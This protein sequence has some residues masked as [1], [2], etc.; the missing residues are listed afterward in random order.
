MMNDHADV[1]REVSE[2]R[3]S[4]RTNEA[5]AGARRA[6]LDN[7]LLRDFRRSNA[8]SGDHNHV[9][10]PQAAALL[11]LFSVA[12]AAQELDR[13]APRDLLSLTLPRRPV[14]RRDYVEF[15]R[16]FARDYEMTPQAD[17]WGWRHGPLRLMPPLAVFALD[18]DRELGQRVKADLRT[19]ARWV[20]QCV[21]TKGVVF[22]LDAATFCIMCAQELRQGGLLT[23]DDETW[24]RDLL[25]KI[26]QHHPAWAEN[27]RMVRG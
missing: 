16:P 12:G 23:A 4:R 7:K 8:M 1:L 24:V 21:A 26:R 15:L 20:D 22:C 9:R 10:A 25:L 5:M 13:Y 2:W 11:L 19:F 3:C 17:Q 18:G 6:H 27:G 14:T